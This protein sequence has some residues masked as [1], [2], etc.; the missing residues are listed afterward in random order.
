MGTRA[1]FKAVN[2]NPA[3]ALRPIAYTHDPDVLASLPHL[4]T[5][6]SAIEVDLSGQMNCEVAGGRYVGALGGALDFLRGANRS[7]GG[8]PIIALPSTAGGRSRIVDVLSGPV[9]IPRGDA[10][11][12]VTEHGVADLRGKSLA[13]RRDLLLAVS[14]PAHVAELE[15]TQPAPGTPSPQETP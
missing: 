6:N 3:F 1:V 5:I 10:S 11:V 2:E 9:T 7:R 15:R 4:V 14:D 13:Q 12:V 8:L